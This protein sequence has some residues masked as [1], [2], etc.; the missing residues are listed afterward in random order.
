[1][2]QAVNSG[3]TEPGGMIDSSRSRATSSFWFGVLFISMVTLLAY[4]SVFSAGFIWDD[5]DH[6]IRISDLDTF[7]GLKRIWTEP[8][9]TMEYYPLVFS[10]FWAQIKLWGLN[11]FGFHLVNIVL[12]TCNALLV[13]LCL[14]R[15]A[16]PGSFWAACI[17]ALHPMHVESVAWVTELK[18]VLSSFFYLLALISYWRFSEVE[19]S[20]PENK[21]A[22]WITYVLSL[23]LFALA[24]L[25]KTATCTL[26]PVILLL[27]WWKRGRIE[28]RALMQLIPFFVLAVLLGLFTIRIEM[29]YLLAKGPEWDFSFIER[30]LIA[31]RATWFHIG[32][33]FWPYPLVFNY[34]RWQLNA[35]AWWQYMFPV[36]VIALLILLWCFRHKT[37]RGPLAACLFILGT[38]FPVLGFLNVY[39][40]RFS[41]V[42]DHYYYI[43]NIGGIVLF[44]AAISRL[45]QKL[46]LVSPSAERVIYGAI[47]LVL[48]LLTWQQGK[49][50]HSN[51]TLFNDTIMKNPASWFSYSNRAVYYVQ[52]GMEDLAMADLEKSLL[53]K[54]DEADALQTQGVIY[55]KRKDFDKALANFDR[56]IAIRPWRTDYLKNRCHAFKVAERFAEA[57]LDAN[58]IIALAAADVDNYILRASI[59]TLQGDYGSA[60]HDLETA[61]NLAPEEFRIYANRGLIYYRQGLLPQAINEYGVALRLNPASSETYFNRGLAHAASGSPAQARSDLGKARELGYELTDQQLT[62]I[63][64]EAVR[65]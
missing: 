27:F 60:L 53:I 16:I 40:F 2:D 29:D 30:I 34:P 44:C 46:L 42:A 12:H 35:D 17:F 11:P 64:A 43:A 33:L 41:F 57:I 3:S 58:R 4:S 52:A 32:K 8:G 22:I 63:I 9:V 59:Y 47:A 61:V 48:S 51:L 7:D 1:M 62:K 55:F 31:G 65:H 54:P 36:T 13:W 37:G 6:V 50:Y 18:N 14:T 20:H 49:I 24:L 56:S 45:Q 26:P 19:G 10:A 5:N 39:S 21:K 25:S 38:N 28:L 23:V 15:L